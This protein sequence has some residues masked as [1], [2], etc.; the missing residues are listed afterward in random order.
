[1]LR[2]IIQRITSPLF[3]ATAAARPEIT[4]TLFQKTNPLFQT[5]AKP[6]T[7]TAHAKSGI[8]LLCDMTEEQMEGFMEEES[9]TPGMFSIKNPLQ[10][11]EEMIREL[12][13][14]KIAAIDDGQAQIALDAVARQ[15]PK[16]KTALLKINLEA[17]E[18]DS[19]IKSLLN[20]V[21]IENNPE[22]KPMAALLL[23][24]NLFDKKEGKYG[25]FFTLY[26]DPK[27]GLFLIDNNGDKYER[28]FCE[29][30]FNEKDYR[31]RK[32]VV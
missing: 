15:Y 25:H 12:Q 14:E 5:P 21:T 13:E 8:E 2:A 18:M 31:D 24:C 3:R 29:R 20:L 10:L 4:S 9:K 26:I 28:T 1:M 30:D 16:L 27:K 22:A 19:K 7:Q 23:P 6:F 32:S 11:Q 17:D